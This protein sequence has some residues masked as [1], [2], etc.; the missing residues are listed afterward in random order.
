LKARIGSVC[1]HPQMSFDNSPAAGLL[2]RLKLCYPVPINLHYKLR[3]EN[4]VHQSRHLNVA[5]LCEKN[6]Q[7]SGKTGPFRTQNPL[8]R[9]PKQYPCGGLWGFSPSSSSHKP[10]NSVHTGTNAPAKPPLPA[11]KTPFFAFILH[12]SALPFCRPSSLLPHPSKMWRGFAQHF[13]SAQKPTLVFR[14]GARHSLG[15]A[16]WRCTAETIAE[17]RAAL[18]LHQRK[19]KEAEDIRCSCIM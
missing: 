15:K 18:T 8:G 11:Q 10:A 6:R 14:N 16:I 13:D 1:G 17:T 5:S 12:P 7:F 9:T 3:N 4:H 2:H 19:R